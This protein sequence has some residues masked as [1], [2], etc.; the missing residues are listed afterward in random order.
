MIHKSVALILA[1]TK[2]KRLPGKNLVPFYGR[3][4]W[5]INVAKCLKLFDRV[6]VS[7]D[8]IELLHEAWEMGAIPI[9]RGEELCGDTPNIPVYQH[10]LGRM[11]DVDSIVAVQA[12]S[13]TVAPQLIEVVKGMM[14]MGVPEVMTVQPDMKLY[15]S[16]WA[17]ATD[18]LKNYGDPYKPEPWGFL[19]D[20]SVDI[21]TEED[22][23]NALRQ[24][25][26]MVGDN[27]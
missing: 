18:R 24:Y 6:Y 20:N 5:Q 16:V 1:K 17:I 13:P 19:V 23:Q 12:N 4:M 9:E 2:S 15:G 11:G 22:Y 26:K 8:G 27:L 3:P 14:E 21:H 25:Y 7:S 10:A